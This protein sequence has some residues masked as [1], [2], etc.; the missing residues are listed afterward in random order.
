M[1]PI[2]RRDR[3]SIR[4]TEQYMTQTVS[5]EKGHHEM[6]IEDLSGPT[7]KDLDE[8][9]APNMSEGGNSVSKDAVARQLSWWIIQ[10]FRTTPSVV[11]GDLR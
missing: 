6:T 9:K 11:R 1:E 2:Q 10:H 5:F 3:A 4:A 8:Q 7:R